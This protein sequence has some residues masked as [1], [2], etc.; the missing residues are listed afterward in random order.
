MRSVN[1]IIPDGKTCNY[2]TREVEYI[3]KCP[4]KSHLDRQLKLDY[5][6]V[7][8]KALDQA[9]A[10]STLRLIVDDMPR[11]ESLINQFES[12]LD[13]PSE[14]V[15]ELAMKY[16]VP[17]ISQ[18]HHEIKKLMKTYSLVTPSFKETYS[19][20]GCTLETTIHLSL[21]SRRGVAKATRYLLID[22]GNYTK[23]W[24]I[25]GKLWV[26][27]LKRSLLEK[28]ISAIDIGV[29]NLKDGKIG[30][31]KANDKN[32]SR[33]MLESICILL[34]G[35]LVYPSVGKHCL[36]CVYQHQCSEAMCP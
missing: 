4:L 23:N 8:H 13:T 14:E 9:I 20:Y 1:K 5:K 29:L 11:V 19:A 2:T 26:A 15:K 10:H 7:M 24:N 22:Y 28:G 34:N 21:R 36:Q 33:E 3:L 32:I 31:P 27:M 16:G 6:P 30:Y 35:E 18:F 17:L 12:R 25:S